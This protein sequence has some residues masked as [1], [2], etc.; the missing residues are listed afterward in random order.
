MADSDGN[1]P[2]RLSGQP[3]IA[4][5]QPADEAWLATRQEEVFRP[6]IA[7]IDPHHHVWDY[8][9][10]RYLFDDV[11]KDLNSGHTVI[12]TVFV[13]CETM[14]RASGPIAMRPVGETE[15]ANGIAARSASGE[16]GATRMCAGIVGTL[17]VRLDADFDDVLQAHIRAGG[18]R[19]RGIRPVVTWHE[20]EQV[21]PWHIAPRLLSSAYAQRAFA[22]VERSGMVLDLWVLFTQL[23]EVEAICRAFPDLTIVLNHCGGPVGIGPYAQNLDEMFLNWRTAIRRVA[24]FPNVHMKIGGLGMAYMGFDFRTR[25]TAPSSDDLAASWKRYVETCIE[26]FGPERCMFESNFPVDK[27]ICS[28]TVLW[29]AF[30]KLADGYSADEKSALFLKSAAD[31]YTLDLA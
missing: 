8:A 14:H 23:D 1:D 16:Y 4:G 13:Q 22:A 18:N 29:N 31:V 10:D 30:K 9:G 11:S 7:I 19:F 27:W 28:Y 25:L 3:N 17:D 5:H 12:A 2:G 24:Q 20:S 15:F 21:R 26:A 6:D